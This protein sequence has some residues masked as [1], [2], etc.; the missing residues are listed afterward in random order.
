MK[1]FISTK[2]YWVP[3]AETYEGTFFKAVTIIDTDVVSGKFPDE[4]LRVSTFL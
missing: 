4:M 2:D 3:F 1:N